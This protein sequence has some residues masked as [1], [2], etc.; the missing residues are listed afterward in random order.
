MVVHFPADQDVD[1]VRS[2]LA[3]V[4][5]VMAPRR[6][7][8]TLMPGD[9]NANPGWAVGFWVAPAALSVLWEDFLQ[10]IGLSRCAPSVEV[11]TWTDDRGC[12]GVIDDAL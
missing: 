11:H 9:L 5:S 4:P 6:G 1:V 8:Y 7:V 10:D 2:L 3:W 12:V